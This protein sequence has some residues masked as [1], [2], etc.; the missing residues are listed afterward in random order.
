[1]AEI[2][3]RAPL[4]L[5]H[6]LP[7]RLRYRASFLKNRWLDRI[8]MEAFVLSI[9]GVEEVRIT[10]GAGSMVI[11]HDGEEATR[12]RLNFRL[13]ELMN[14]PLRYREIPEPHAVPG[15]SQVVQGGVAT[16]A[17]TLLP[18][19][20]KAVVTFANIAGTLLSGLKVLAT[21]GMKVE[22]LDTIAVGLSA[23]RGEY[24]T[25]NATDWFLHLGEYLEHK[26]QRQSEDLLRNL[27]AP[28]PTK[29]W[30]QQGEHLKQIPFSE[31][32]HGD[33]VVV[34]V[35]ELIPVDGE[36]I[37]GLAEVN[38]SSVTGESHPVRRE[39]GGHVVSGTVVENGRITI[40]AN[41]VGSET[42]TAKITRFI[43][44]SLRAS[45]TTESMAEQLADKRVM[46]T[47]G[48][49]ALV[50]GVT[51]DWQ[52][53]ASVF[54]VDYSCSI[55]FSTPVAFQSSMRH[56]AEHGILI[57]GGQV[58]EGFAAADTFVFDKTGTLT[59]GEM[60]V[61]DVVSLRKG[62]SKDKLL[63][64]VASTEEHVNHPMA[65]AVVNHASDNN[66]PHLDHGE[67]DFIVAHGLRAKVGRQAVLVGSRHFLEE[68]EGVDFSMHQQKIDQLELEG[69]SLLYIS[70]NEKPLGLVALKDQVRPEALDTVK[71]LRNLGVK[72]LIMLTGDREE[73]AR[74]QARE[75][76]M[77]DV[78]FELHPEEK[79]MIVE[80]LQAEGQRVVFI[81]DGVNDA[82]ALVAADSGVAMPKGADIARASA[83]VVLMDDSIAAVAGT[84]EIAE[85]TMAMI[86]NNFAAAIGINSGVMLGAVSGKLSP[87]ASSILH[88]GATVGILF[89]SLRGVD[90]PSR[91]AAA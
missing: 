90:L 17:A 11:Q 43:E 59:K 84:R 38:Q 3:P 51:R 29:V 10:L 48:L 66:L 26:T 8:W 82:P 60:K 67:V 15:F 34:G 64:L 72:R 23:W 78:Y 30:V 1:M 7:K 63:A 9:E 61:T 25:A 2:G 65:S 40:E 91:E 73:R 45:S 47:L 75:L 53:L 85:Q 83:D 22:V 58:I 27:L 49:G 77:D 52:R 33:H 19:P 76:V 36:V 31:V 13:Q 12:K 35:G 80:K 28:Q 46:L 41:K 18:P 37:E 5:A 54:L 81:G 21:E 50:Y 70:G 62:W 42:T 89:N 24:F 69:K 44:E 57:K 39:V 6:E 20:L 68:D 16:V 4:L 14:T 56:A 86:R 87:I 74:A 32:Q 55:K 79:A 88:N 71:R